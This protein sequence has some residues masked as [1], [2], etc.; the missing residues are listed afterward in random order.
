MIIA[1]I[2]L[3]LAVCVYERG[4]VDWGDGNFRNA[5]CRMFC[6]R[7]CIRGRIKKP[8]GKCKADC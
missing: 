2:Y 6:V 3:S 8:R 4:S 5:I 1:C 7:I